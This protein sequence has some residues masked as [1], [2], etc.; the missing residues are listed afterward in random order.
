MK[1]TSCSWSISFLEAR[2]RGPRRCGGPRRGFGESH[3]RG[4]VDPGAMHVPPCPNEKSGKGD[5]KPARET[6]DRRS[7]GHG[8]RGF[9][10]WEQQRSFTEVQGNEDWRF[11]VVG[12]KSRQ[13]LDC[14]CLQHRFPTAATRPVSPHGRR[15]PEAK[16]PVKP[17]ALQ[18]LARAISLFP[19]GPVRLPPFTP[20]FR[21]EPRRTW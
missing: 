7:E 13:R 6:A 14:A 20:E 1:E 11:G 8:S 17:D 12:R 2:H 9:H 19:N 21:E 16:A 5:R 10:G 15:C 4:L 3:G 18:T